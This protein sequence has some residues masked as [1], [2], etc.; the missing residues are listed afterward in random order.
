MTANRKTVPL[1]GTCPARGT[2]VLATRRIGRPFILRRIRA[3]FPPGCQGLLALAFY[4]SEDPTTPASGPPTGLSVLQE[5]S[6]TDTL[7]GDSDTKDLLTE[8]E[9]PLGG[10]WLKVYAANTDY[11]DHAVDVQLTFDTLGRED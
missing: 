6:S 5:Y 8:L 4:L 3:T 10:T 9:Q 1:A 2:L 11:Y 7:T